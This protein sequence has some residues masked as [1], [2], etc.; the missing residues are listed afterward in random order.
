MVMD[1][2]IAGKAGPL[3]RS[4]CARPGMSQDRNSVYTARVGRSVDTYGCAWRMGSGCGGSL[5]LR[6]R[7]HSEILG[8]YEPKWIEKVDTLL[9]G[10]ILAGGATA[11][12]VA[13]GATPLA[14]LAA[15]GLIWGW[16]DQKGLA[17]GLL[18]KAVASVCP[19]RWLT[20]EDL[21]A[22]ELI[23]AAHSTIVVAALFESFQVHVGKEFYDQLSITDERE[24][25][26]ARPDGTRGAESVVGSIYV[27]EIPAPSAARGFAENLEDVLNWQADFA[28]SLQ[29]FLRGLAVSEKTQIDWG[30]VLEGAIERY[31]SHILSSR[32][33]S[34]SSR[35]GPNSGSTRRR[36]GCA[37]G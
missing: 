22:G 26:P 32:R 31:R 33:R 8:H 28:A 30:A 34:G 25:S 2:H 27:S 19:G 24:D 1:I 3:L 15:F 36:D 5:V 20:P 4:S 12:L 23:A 14:P 10:A 9:G 37:R 13:L 35:S 21:S 16:V 18:R 11:G 7:G 29:R 17:V 6:L